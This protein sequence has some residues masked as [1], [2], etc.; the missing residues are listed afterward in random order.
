[1]EKAK[2]YSALGSLIVAAILAF[3]AFHM[4][5]E[6]TANMLILVAQFLMYS[7]TLYGF[8]EI[9]RRIYKTNSHVKG[10]VD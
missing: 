3:S 2:T 5:D 9:A 8:G 7:L 6:I 10:K 4:K 1:M